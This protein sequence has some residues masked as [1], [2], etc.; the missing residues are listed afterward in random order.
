[1]TRRIL[2]ILGLPLAATVKELLQARCPC[3]EPHDGWPGDNGTQLCQMCWEAACSDAW[4][5]AVELV[6]AEE[7]Q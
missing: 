5:R 6:D 7:R 2:A 4:W 3:G 1:M